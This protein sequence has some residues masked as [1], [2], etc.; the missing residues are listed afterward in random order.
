MKVN[1]HLADVTYRITLKRRLKEFIPVIFQE[2][3]KDWGQLDI[4]LCSDKYLLQMNK[5][6]LS[7]DYY[8]DILTFDLSSNEEK[9][10]GEI[11]ISIDRVKENANNMGMGVDNEL[12]RVIFHGVLHLCGHNDST[13]KLKEEIHKM[14][15]SYLNL[16]EE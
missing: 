3:E 6:H 14:E 1:F 4:I 5:E 12:T 13:K 15:D 2:E 7:H 9:G 11:Y 10:I 8:T 16:F